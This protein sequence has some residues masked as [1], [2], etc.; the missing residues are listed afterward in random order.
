MGDQRAGEA[1]QCGTEAQREGDRDEREA[2]DA[3]RAV[4]V[5]VIGGAPFERGQRS[6]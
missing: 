6:G 2:E 3:G 4:R 1:Q 5:V